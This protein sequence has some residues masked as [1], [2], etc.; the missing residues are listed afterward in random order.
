VPPLEVI[1]EGYQAIAAQFL[2]WL[3][4]GPPP[5]T[6]ADNLPSTAMLFAAIRVSETGTTIDVQEVA[7]QLIGA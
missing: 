1:W 2:D 3:D 5:T 7:R 6:L 4:G